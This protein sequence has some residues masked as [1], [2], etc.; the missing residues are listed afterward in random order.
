MQ[1]LPVIVKAVKCRGFTTCCFPQN[2]VTVFYKYE[3]QI[4]KPFLY[5]KPQFKINMCLIKLVY[6]SN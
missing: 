6:E 2:H 1:S 5:I 3:N 4:A